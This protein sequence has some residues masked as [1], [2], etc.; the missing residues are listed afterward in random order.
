[1][2][3][4]KIAII[5]SGKIGELVIALLAPDYTVSVFDKDPERAK[6]AA[7]GIAEACGL[8]VNDGKAVLHA[9][10]GNELLINCCPHFCN[11]PLAKAARTADISYIDLSEDVKSGNEIKELAVGAS[12]YFVPRCGIAPGFIN[13]INAC[14]L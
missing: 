4:D 9:I 10:E 8:D 5:G 6:E 3:K 13:V 1:M 14:C 12:G 7:Q 2:S 11:L